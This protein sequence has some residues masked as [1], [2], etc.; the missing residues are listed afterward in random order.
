[1]VRRHRILRV[2]FRNDRLAVS[3]AHG[4][5][6]GT[7]GARRREGFV[8]PW[9]NDP[10]M[11]RPGY[12]ARWKTGPEPVGQSEPNAYGLFEM[13]ETYMSGVAIGSEQTTIRFLLTGIRRDR[14]KATEKHRAEVRGGT[15]SR[16]HDVRHVPAFR[17]NSNTL[18]MAFGWLATGLGELIS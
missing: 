9:G 8:F 7:G 15:K 18:I 4:S 13:C 10:P 3:A 12:H 16:S 5:R 17:R 1:M 14:K 11:S 2:A 6:V